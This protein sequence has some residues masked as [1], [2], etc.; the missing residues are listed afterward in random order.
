MSNKSLPAREKRR[1]C[2]SQQTLD[3]LRITIKSFTE[4]G[5]VL[6]K[7]PGVKYLCS[8][9]FSQDPV[10]RYF[11]KQRHRGGEN[12]NPTV[13]EFRTNTATLIH[14][15]AVHKDLKTMNVEP[16]S[17]QLDLDSICQPLPKRIRKH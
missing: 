1:K 16:S 13:H 9:V 8:E 4:L 3:G 6:L 2:L 5:P 10:E 12:D 15:L 11:S 17:S 14:Q 7:N